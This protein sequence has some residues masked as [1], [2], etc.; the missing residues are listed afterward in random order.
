[1]LALHR[2]LNYLGYAFIYSFYSLLWCVFPYE[3]RSVHP[4][5]NQNLRQRFPGPEWYRS[6]RCRR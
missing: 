4:A 2:R 6:G 3:F 5:A 1:M